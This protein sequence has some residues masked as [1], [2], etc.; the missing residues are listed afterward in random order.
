LPQKKLGLALGGGGSRALC[1]LGVLTA[2]ENAG[3]EI[4]AVAGNSMGALIGAVYAHRGDAAQTRREVAQFFTADRAFTKSKGDGLTRGNGFF[5]YA[6]RCL[7]SLAISLVLSFRNGFLRGNPCAQAI[8]A[9]AP[10]L[11]I[12]DLPLPFASVAL[13]LTDGKLENFTAGDLR[14]A[15]T[16]GTNIGVVFKPF[17]WRG[18]MYIDAAPVR[19]VPAAEARALGVEVVLAVDI[20]SP[21]PENYAVQNGMDV[22][23]RLEQIESKMLNDQTLAAADLVVRPPVSQIF[24]GDFSRAAEIIAIGEQATNAA[25]PQLRRLLAADSQ[26]LTIDN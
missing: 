22:V 3:I 18:K 11:S 20:R 7:R 12:E 4:H 10:A 16:A 13:N 14:S 17:A 6:K 1:H 8:A 25:L 23:M 24:W 26:Q 9:L 15:L 2:L 5:I 19:S 21:L